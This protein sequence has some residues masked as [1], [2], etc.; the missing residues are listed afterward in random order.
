MFY[1]K[2]TKQELDLM[3]R[4][5]GITP[6]F[7]FENYV[8]NRNE[9]TGEVIEEYYTNLTIHMTADEAYQKDLEDKGKPS[10]PS[11]MEVLKA[12]VDGIENINAGLLFENAEH[13]IKI[14]EQEKMNKE[15]E[16]TNANLL[17]EIAM[18]K[19]AML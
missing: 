17:L 2:I 5:D 9:E 18:L 19:G 14:K 13:Q 12:R 10:E 3:E 1:K 6:N 11:K 7:T 16:V 15:Q 8:I 4:P